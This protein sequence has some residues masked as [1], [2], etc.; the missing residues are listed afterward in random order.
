MKLPSGDRE[1][2]LD[3]DAPALRW[4]LVESFWRRLVS[5]SPSFAVELAFAVEL[6]CAVVLVSVR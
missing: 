3:R 5:V 1:S 6:F 4:V 2:S